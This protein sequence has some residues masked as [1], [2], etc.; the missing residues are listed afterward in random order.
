MNARIVALQSA[1]SV[2]TL[3]FG[4][5]A[6]VAVLFCACERF[7][8]CPSTADIAPS[9]AELPE[10]LSST[11]LYSQLDGEHEAIASGVLAYTPGF[12]LWSDGASKRRWV[13]LPEGGVI[14]VRDPDDWQFPKG[15]KLWKEFT[16]DGVRV[17]T[18]MM[19]KFGNGEGDWAAAAYVWLADNSDAE[20]KPEGAINA[21]GTPHDVPAADRCMGCHGGRR[22]RV[23]GFSAV[24]L[25]SARGDDPLTLSDLFAAG[26]LSAE[27]PEMIVPGNDIE[28][29]ALG[30]LH[31]NCS[32][33]HNANRPETDGPRCYD[34]RN[35]LDM[36][37]KLSRLGNVRDTPTYE[38]LVGSE[39]EPGDP[40]GSKLFELVS[41][42]SKG[43]IGTD[44]MPPLASERVDEDGVALLREWIAEL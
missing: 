34:P 21:R 40:E 23:L 1:I 35:D 38:T 6:A 39:V 8:E 17:E 16:R 7:D 22:G 29:A 42:R 37:L 5:I 3:S 41:R 25:A 15:T 36:F 26:V 28:R 11:G 20:L 32:H 18:R 14:D 9:V 12:E 31:A 19:L 24:Q 30:Y 10:R 27:V 4:R 13:S 44:Q 33:C 2:Y 43:E